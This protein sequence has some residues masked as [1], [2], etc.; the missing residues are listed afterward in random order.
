MRNILYLIFAVSLLSSC[1][2]LKQN[3]E[4]NKE[5]IIYIVPDTVQLWFDNVIK[6]PRLISKKE[7]IY[8]IIG[9]IERNNK[10]LYDITLCDG[11]KFDFRDDFFVKNTNRYVY[12]KGNLY[13]L[14]SDLDQIFSTRDYTNEELLNLLD[15]PEDIE[16]FYKIYEKAVFWVVFNKKW[17]D[18]IETSDESKGGY[19]TNS[20]N[21]VKP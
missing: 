15:T 17:G 16:Q 5:K 12:I 18:I 7:N 2:S 13:P 4:T 11:D 8:F 9:Q 19:R 1:T 10:L 3:A 20:P 21:K 6:E 14:L